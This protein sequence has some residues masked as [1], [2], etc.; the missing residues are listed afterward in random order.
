MCVCAC[1]HACMRVQEGTFLFLSSY[2]KK[3]NMMW[4]A[5][6]RVEILEGWLD[7]KPVLQEEKPCLRKQYLMGRKLYRLNA[8]HHLETMSP[9]V[10]HPSSSCRSDSF[11]LA[12]FF[13]YLLTSV[14]LPSECV[15][16]SVWAVLGPQALYEYSLRCK[17]G[18]Q[19]TVTL[20]VSTHF[21]FGVNGWGFGLL[22]IFVVFKGNWHF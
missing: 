8:C 22:F 1:V 11:S 15:S 9:H 13:L 3:S 19:N 16:R 6:L 5:L 20:R 18:P 4:E 12:G 7:F 2:F 10:C 17:A 14:I 21:A